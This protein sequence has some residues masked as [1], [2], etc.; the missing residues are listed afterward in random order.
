MDAHWSAA[1]IK[2]VF[3]YTIELADLESVDPEL[4]TQRI[5][6][7]VTSLY[8]SRDGMQLAD[9]GLTFVDNSNDEAYTAGGGVA[10][11]E[12][13]PGGSEIEV[14]KDNVEE[15]LQLFVHRRLCHA[16]KPQVDAV[17]E[18]LAVFVSDELRASLR[19]FC[20]FRDIQLLISGVA[21]IDVDDWE[22]SARYRVYTAESREVR[23]FWRLVRAMDAEQVQRGL[24]P[25]L[26]PLRSL[27]PSP[28]PSH[29]SA[30]KSCICLTLSHFVCLVLSRS[31]AL[32]SSAS[33]SVSLSLC[34]SG[35][36]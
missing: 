32:P 2:A 16:I 20:T 1:F 34:V 21:E 25:P 22:A 23:W 12:L 27:A 19:E 18:G 24:A 36:V 14:T 28:P 30:L 31:P 33:R 29:L 11:V 3:G 10:S 15:Y 8:S 4:Y 17:V 7:L 26:V 5:Q 9:L 6:Y 13:K 35:N